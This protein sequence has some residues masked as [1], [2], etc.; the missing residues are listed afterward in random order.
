MIVFDAGV[1]GHSVNRC[2]EVDGCLWF[3]SMR[4]Q[5]QASAKTTHPD[6][7]TLPLAAIS[8]DHSPVRRPNIDAFPVP[9]CEVH[10][11]YHMNAE[12]VYL[13]GCVAVLYLGLAPP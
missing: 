12:T 8:P 2:R 6:I 9:F 1:L 10:T 11:S 5:R 3:T 4:A 13:E 7:E